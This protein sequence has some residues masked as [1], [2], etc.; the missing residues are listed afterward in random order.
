[1]LGTLGGMQPMI[2]MSRAGATDLT[3]LAG[4][5]ASGDWLINFSANTRFL[6]AWLCHNFSA[7]G[8]VQIYLSVVQ[9]HRR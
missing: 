3:N 1:M 6:Y 5:Q 8:F 4:R 9:S 7:V 2:S